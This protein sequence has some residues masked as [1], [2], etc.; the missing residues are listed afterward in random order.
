MKKY[1]IFC[2]AFVLIACAAPATE[3]VPTV[4]FTATPVTPSP[5]PDTPE[6]QTFLNVFGDEPIVSKGS[7]GTWDDRFTDPGAVVFYDG[8]FHMFRN[9]FRGFPAT[10]QVGYVT[11]PDGYTWTKQGDEPVFE[12]KDVAYAKIAMY[13]SSALVEEDGT[14]VIYFYTWDSS[15]FPGS[16]VIGRATATDPNGPWVADEQPVL[17][18]GA[19]GEWDER[20][21]LAPHVIQT[22]DGYIMYYSG[23]NNAGRQQVGMA[24]SSD[25]IQWTKYND[26]ATTEAP[27]IESD[28]VFQPGES[29][30]WDANSV[31][32]PRV[33]E[34]A[35]GWVMIYRGTKDK[36]GNTMALGLAT[37][38]DGIH[39]NRS[40]VNPVF[41]PSDIP[42]AAY[43]WFH[44]AL[45]VDDTYFIFIEGDISQTTQIY[46]A[47]YE[48]AIPK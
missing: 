47:T 42:G 14:W 28:P 18:L 26:P 38:D 11:S 8:V 4:E 34:T 5:I 29:G 31:H 6:P 30:S 19:S 48:G 21:V 27:T 3:V 46:L 24:T 9:G 7:S 35:Q 37:S 32:Q 39:W 2:L 45:L 12:T 36:S 43:F 22:D 23:S 15:S 16:S 41:I 17:L 20:Q 33:F 1:F 10:S 13:A 40:A 44:N 25:G